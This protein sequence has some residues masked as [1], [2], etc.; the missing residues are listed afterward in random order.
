MRAATDWVAAAGA[1]A[2]PP[3]DA[4]APFVTPAPARF[5]PPPQPAT[6]PPTEAIVSARNILQPTLADPSRRI[7]KQSMNAATASEGRP[8]AVASGRFRATHIATAFAHERLRR[9][10][11]ESA[12]MDRPA[13]LTSDDARALLAPHEGRSLA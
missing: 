5:A 6:V 9:S 3:T 12:G 4:C 8:S 1:P 11:T 7:K 10:P 2:P 13:I